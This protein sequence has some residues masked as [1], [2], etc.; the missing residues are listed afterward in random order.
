VPLTVTKNE[1]VLDGMKMVMNTNK[2][3]RAGDDITFNMDVTDAATGK[4]I[5]NLQPYLGAWSHIA[6]VSE[7]TQDFLHVHP[8]EVPGEPT[9][10]AWKT[11]GPSP[12]FI[13]TISGFRKPGLYK[14]WVQIQRNGKVSDM[15][16]VYKVAPAGTNVSQ[17]VPHAPPG[18]VLVN[19]SSSGFAPAT[20][21][22][23]AGKP[24]K[25]AFFRPD[26]ANCASSVVFPSMN[27]KKDLP[28]GQT[29]IVDVT[30]T[31]SGNLGFECGMK[32]FRGQLIVK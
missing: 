5:H 14:M 7:D 27:V 13:R 17:A 26:A 18:S 3:L 19:V 2:P 11:G 32:M 20:I 30:P 1:C 25:L 29:T 23:T 8:M 6:V 4:P 31:K 9:A 16:F 10:T 22:A 21:Q 24:L 12:S 28:P 15:A